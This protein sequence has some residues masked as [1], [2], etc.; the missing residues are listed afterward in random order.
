[1]QKLKRQRSYGQA[2]K[3]LI[4]YCAFSGVKSCTESN[5]Q[6]DFFWY[7]RGQN[8]W[9]SFGI[10]NETYSS[11]QALSQ[12]RW[13]LLKSLLAVSLR[14]SKVP[15]VVASLREARS[16]PYFG[17]HTEDIFSLQTFCQFFSEARI[18]RTAMHS[19]KPIRI[20]HHTTSK[21]VQTDMT[22]LS[23]KKMDYI[24]ITEYKLRTESD[25]SWKKTKNGKT[26]SQS[27]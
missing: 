8:K 17:F 13:K 5:K 21:A 14:D 26:K 2:F 24:K 3:S 16:S 11:G 27:N 19:R 10:Y 20:F 7:S 22:K 12:S 9:L 23:Q 18:G 1:M 25:H 15:E 4:Q 6:S